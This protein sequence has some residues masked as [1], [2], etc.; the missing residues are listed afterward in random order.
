MKLLELVYVMSKN[1]QN[2]PLY[3]HSQNIVEA[4]L[5]YCNF[6]IVC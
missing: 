3:I 4:N 2:N 1:I 5:S 6:I